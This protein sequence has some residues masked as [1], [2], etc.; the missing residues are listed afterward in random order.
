MEKKE[1]LYTVDGTLN[2][3]SQYG[4][5][6]RG[7]TKKLKIELPYDPSVLEI[8]T[9]WYPYSKKYCIV[10]LKICQRG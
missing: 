9:A 7:T 10:F 4:K 2:W 6:Y 1:P 3:C 5:P 8:G